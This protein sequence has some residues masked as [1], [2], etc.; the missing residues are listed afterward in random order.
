[1]GRRRRQTTGKGVFSHPS[2]PNPHNPVSVSP[3]TPLRSNE[4]YKTPRSK[5]MKKM[6]YVRIVVCG[7][8]DN[9]KSLKIGEIKKKSV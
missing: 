1:M 6:P 2:H 8:T 9:G 3:Q 7:D 4:E 5:G